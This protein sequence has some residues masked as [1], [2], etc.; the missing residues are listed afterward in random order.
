M[1]KDW[2]KLRTIQKEYF[3]FLLSETVMP[4]LCLYTRNSNH[5]FKISVLVQQIKYCFIPTIELVELQLGSAHI[6]NAICRT[7]R[8]LVLPNYSW[9][10]PTIVGFTKL[11]L[12]SPNYSWVHQTTVGITQL[13]L[14]SP[15]YSWVHQTIVGFTKLQLDHPTCRCTGLTVVGQTRLSLVDPSVLCQADYSWSGPT[16]VLLILQCGRN[17]IMIFKQYI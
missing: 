14:G 16:I 6:D 7:I 4:S 8:F 9:D 1:K 13:Q 12:G 10:H 15:N 11:Q 17:N 5:T 3:Q 2:H